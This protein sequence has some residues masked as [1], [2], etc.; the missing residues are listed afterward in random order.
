MY[1][2]IYLS[3]SHIHIVKLPPSLPPPPHTHTLHSLVGISSSNS[4]GVSAT[5]AKK[6][7][8][9]HDEFDADILPLDGD[10]DG[11]TLF[12]GTA[13]RHGCTNDVR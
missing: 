4:A 6:V 5:T 1:I 11:E 8:A 10:F 7:V 12:V 3:I 13:L 2:Y 9:Y